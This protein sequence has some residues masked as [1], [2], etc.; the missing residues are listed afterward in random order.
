MSNDAW[1]QISEL[2]NHNQQELWRINK[3]F[4]DEQLSQ[5][6]EF[7][8]S[9]DPFSPKREQYFS[10]EIEYLIEKGVKDFI[11]DGDLWKAIW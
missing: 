9:H 11:K 2:T 1:N 8:F 5:R 3:A 7:Y 10:L 4:L 6:K